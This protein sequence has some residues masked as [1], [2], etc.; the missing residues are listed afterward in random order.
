MPEII[1]QFISEAAKKRYKR[2]GAK[3]HS[4][5]SIYYSVLKVESYSMKGDGFVVLTNDDGEIWWVVNRDVRVM[6]TE[7]LMSNG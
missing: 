6:N 5:R 3:A 7:D 2:R 4:W 1:V